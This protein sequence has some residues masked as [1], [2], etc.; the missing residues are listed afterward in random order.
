MSPVDDAIRVTAIDG[1]VNGWI[2][3]VRAHPSATLYHTLEW[4]EILEH[5]FGYRSWC[6]IASTAAG[7]IVG[8]LPLY[9]VSSP[10]GKRLV[11]VPFRDRGGP[12]WTDAAAFPALVHECKRI[13]A[14]VGA[15]AIELKS[16][17]PYPH[18]LVTD[19]GLQERYHWVRSTIA[20]ASFAGESL[21]QQL[22]AKR[23]SPIRQA[24]DGGMQCDDAGTDAR[25]WYGLHL[26]TQQRLGLPPF[27]LKFF[28]K[29]LDTLVPIGAAQLLVAS[30]GG[31]P[32]AAAILLKHR[33]D[34]V[35][36]YAASSAD[37]QR[38]AAVDV[39]LFTAIE[40][41]IAQGRDVFDMGSDAP[42]QS[43]L[44][45][46]KK[47]WFA[48]Q[49]PIPSYRIGGGEGVDSSSP[50]YQLIRK[51]FQYLPRP[52]LRLTSMATKYFG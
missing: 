20:L 6:L 51:G 22:G 17:E 52:V 13:A 38:Q 14:E 8:A 46:F 21:S 27:P 37:G 23:R 40:A 36:G 4:R 1:N 50:R 26:E 30:R 25:A 41:A 44:L 29:L 33:N 35:Y 31:R 11:A 5:S 42:S 48:A 34:V 3:F 10:I 24:L 47:R 9:F 43:G 12:L 7:R 32:L 39:V 2:E 16:V 28:S 45:F 15:D 49:A 18:E 19:S